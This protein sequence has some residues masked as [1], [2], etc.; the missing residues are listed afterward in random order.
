MRKHSSICY[1]CYHEFRALMWHDIL[2]TCTHFFILYYLS[3][4]SIKFKLKKCQKCKVNHTNQWRQII[5]SDDFNKRRHSS[6][7]QIVYSHASVELKIQTGLI[8]LLKSMALT[9]TELYK[10]NLHIKFVQISHFYC[11]GTVPS[12]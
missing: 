12:I 9:V 6:T 5:Y 7:E 3:L 4:N 8:K 1:H 10:F 2:L 11:A